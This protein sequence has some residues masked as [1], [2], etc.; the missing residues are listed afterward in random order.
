LSVLYPAWIVFWNVRHI[1][2]NQTTRISGNIFSSL[3]RK[4]SISVAIDKNSVLC[5]PVGPID[6]SESSHFLVLKNTFGPSGGPRRGNLSFPK[7]SCIFHLKNRSQN[8]KA[9]APALAIATAM[10]PAMAM[11]TVT[12]IATTMTTVMVTG[13][14]NAY[15]N[16]GDGCD[17]GGNDGNGN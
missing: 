4:D 9:P 3:K 17:A 15:G 14:N 10:A 16:N 5:C 12:V 7:K 6:I 2:N 1:L 13:S 11:P 8:K